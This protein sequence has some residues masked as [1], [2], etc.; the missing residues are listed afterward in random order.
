MNVVFG[1]CGNEATRQIKE[2]SRA[3]S[4]ACADSGSSRQLFMETAAPLQTLPSLITRTCVWKTRAGQAQSSISAV[5]QLY[6][7]LGVHFL[8]RCEFLPVT[9]ITTS[10]I[11]LA[12]SKGNSLLGEEPRGD[13]CEELCLH[14]IGCMD[15]QQTWSPPS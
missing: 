2:S 6:L 3:L 13:F 1:P 9:L 5:A 12:E 10:C 15:I 4:L 11:S 14:V 8:P 7:V